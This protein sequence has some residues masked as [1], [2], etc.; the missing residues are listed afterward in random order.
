MTIDASGP[1]AATALLAIGARVARLSTPVLSDVLDAMGLPERA[2]SNAIR[3]L[4]GALK[5]AGPARCVIGRESGVAYQG[6]PAAG[7]AMDRHVV[8][9]DVIVVDTGGHRA[10]SIFGGNVALALKRRGCAGVVVDGTL[11]DAEE[12]ESLALPAYGRGLTPKSN[13]GRWRVVDLDR[14]LRL[15]GQTTEHVDIA[16]G[17]WIVGDA[18]G[19]I[20]IPGSLV[21]TVVAAAERLEETTALREH[22]T[23]LSLA[24][25]RGASRTSSPPPSRRSSPR[26]ARGEARRP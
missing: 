13:K 6:I 8:P 26:C 17:D 18:D 5:F 25:I 2:L 24:G 10:T 22:R 20:A 12:W 1:S 21:E 11:R 14:G 7:F 19:V 4:V 23:G 16:P 9:G 15:P 3:G